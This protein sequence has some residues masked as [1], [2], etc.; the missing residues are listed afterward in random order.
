MMPAVD[1]GYAAAEERWLSTYRRRADTFRKRGPDDDELEVI[2]FAETLVRRIGMDRA[3]FC[4]ASVA[5]WLAD[6]QMAEMLER[7]VGRRRP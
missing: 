2:A 5:R 7:D 3:R 6:V 4:L 1:G